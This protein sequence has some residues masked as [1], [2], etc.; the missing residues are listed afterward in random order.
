MDVKR[1]SAVHD[2]IYKV[3]SATFKTR[4]RTVDHLGREQIADCPTAISELWKNSYDA[5]ATSAKIDLFKKPSHGDIALLSDD[6]HGMSLE[7]FTERW[8]TI[9]TESKATDNATDA[10]YRNGMPVRPKLGQKGIGRLSSAKLGPLLLLISRKKGCDPIAALLDWRLFENSYLNLSD[11]RVAV[12][13]IGPEGLV[14]LLKEMAHEVL[15]SVYPDPEIDDRASEI[16]AAWETFDADRAKKNLSSMAELIREDLENLPFGEEHW[17]VWQTVD[18]NMHHGTAMLVARLNFDLRALVS[19]DEFT[20]T[21]A[22]SSKRR[23]VSTLSNFI[24]PYSIDGTAVVGEFDYGVY[25]NVNDERRV[26]LEKANGLSPEVVA[27]AEHKVSGR[28]SDDGVFTGTLTVFGSVIKDV[29]ISPPSDLPARTRRDTR[30]GGFDIFLATAEWQEDSS[31]LETAQWRRFT[32]QADKHSGLLIFRDGLRVMPYGRLDNDYFEIESRRGKNAGAAFWVNRRLFGR[33]SVSRAGNPNLKDKAGR[34]GFIDNQA[35]KIFREL[36]INVLRESAKQYFGRHSEM[37]KVNLP[38]IKK[39]NKNAK[40]LQQEKARRKKDAERF[41]AA[42]NLKA[43]VASQ[44]AIEIIELSA[45]A[46]LT[47]QAD[48]ISTTDKLES[49]STRLMK[50]TVAAPASTLTP[51]VKRK[52]SEYKSDLDK[53]VTLRDELFAILAKRVEALES[54]DPHTLLSGQLK[55]GMKRH[56]AVLA[57]ES[58]STGQVLE[59]ERKRL[60]SIRRERSKNLETDARAIF[61]RFEA[62]V[63]EYN[64]ASDELSKLFN[65]TVEETLDIFGGYR[66]ALE[67]LSDNIDLDYLIR[68]GVSERSDMKAEADKLTSLAQLGIAVEITGHEIN[69]YGRIID[70]GIA[71]LPEKL[72]ETNAFTD[73][74]FGVA[75]LTEHLKLIAPLQLSGHQIRTEISGEDIVEFLQ[76]FFALPFKEKA[77]FMTASEEFRKASIFEL[78]SRV[79][80]VFINLVNNALYWASQGNAPNERR[81]HLERLDNNLIVS[82]NGP[83]VA[84]EDLEYLFTLFFTKRDSGRGVGLYLAAASLASGGHALRYLKDGDPSLLRGGNFAIEFR[85]LSHE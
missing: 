42:L 35:S 75:G 80:P 41:A 74:A 14:P 15:R 16:S 43:P 17:N 66:R 81:V 64:R 27:M 39:R 82:D 40:A 32:D 29:V 49:I 61:S 65:S 51:S 45:S 20:D 69:D 30:V 19:P 48:I 37:R 83:G 21:T 55:R 56:A 3:T 23:F 60:Y 63:V 47:D 76:K 9:G 8:L 1:L 10:I 77:V 4:A 70:E 38:E 26:L 57:E 73:I 11:I 24:D 85:G 12:R 28:I 59:V 13:T 2:W 71:A 31:T 50:A 78:K 79:F 18:E 22:V 67:V 58:N 36:V 54:V 84:P 62:G 5:Y 46:K 53:I 44:L 72:R 7:D 25:A 33:V 68:F 6:G 34:E 52:Y